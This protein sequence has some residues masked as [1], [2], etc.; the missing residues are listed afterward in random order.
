MDIRKSESSIGDVFFRFGLTGVLAC[1]MAA[2]SLA[3]ASSPAAALISTYELP[4]VIS[5]TKAK[6]VTAML[7]E[8]LAQCEDDYL[9]AR[10]RY[11]IGVIYF[12]GRMLDAAGSSFQC[13]ASD[14]NAPQLLR[15][16]SLNMAG[17]CARMLGRDSEALEAFEEL[18]RL[19][20]KALSARGSNT[21]AAALRRL[22]CAAVFS[23]A[24]IMETRAEYAA[25]IT[26][27]GRLLQVL[28]RGKD[29]QLPGSYAALA[30]D[31]MG[32]LHLRRGDVDAYLKAAASLC[33]DYP[34][35]YRTPVAK[36]EAECVKFLKKV[37]AD[38]QFINGSFAAPAQAIGYLKSRNAE[39][40]AAELLAVIEALCRQYE[41]SYGGSVLQYH[42]AWLLDT[43]G[44][45]DEAVETFT[46]VASAE[47]VDADGNRLKRQ[48]LETIQE[49]ARIQSAIMYGEKADYS[50]ALRMLGSLRAHPDQSHLSKLAKSVTEA[51]QVLKKEVGKSE[52]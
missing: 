52:D 28:C 46:R 1:A 33:T 26:E 31:R 35:Y 39:V 32:Q 18:A 38:S 36:F 16:C 25:A 20:E 14:S 12:K 21:R 23:R 48:A 22:W 49:Y 15:I 9:R 34:Q 51:I 17:Q 29:L 50:E 19:A 30:K 42:H 7:E 45:K 43:L 2:V 6:E 11:R 27:Y 8:S 44:K 13:V 40:A 41:N 3:E 37:S 10:I 47:P 24:E 4:A 5:A